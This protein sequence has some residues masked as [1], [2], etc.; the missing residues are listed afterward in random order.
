MDAG[1]VEGFDGFQQLLIGEEPFS[2][3]TG[4]DGESIDFSV[5]NASIN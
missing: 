5:L 4:S 3:N 2:S 1:A